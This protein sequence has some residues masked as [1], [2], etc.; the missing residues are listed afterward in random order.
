MK[1]VALKSIFLLSVIVMVDYLLMILVGCI[2]DYAGCTTTY[3]ECTFCTIGKFVI[4]IS[5]IV[6]MFLMMHDFKS[7]VAKPKSD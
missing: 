5:A 3:F 6:F 4:A 7:I 1:N 2:S